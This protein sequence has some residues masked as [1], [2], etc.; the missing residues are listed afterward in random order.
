MAPRPKYNSTE[1]YNRDEYSD[2]YLVYKSC[3]LVSKSKA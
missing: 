2:V 1:V 3:D